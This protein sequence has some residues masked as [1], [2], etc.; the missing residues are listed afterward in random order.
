MDTEVYKDELKAI[1]DTV[2][3]GGRRRGGE[4]RE[5]VEEREGGEKVYDIDRGVSS[6]FFCAYSNIL[7][8]AAVSKAYSLDW[9]VCPPC[10]LT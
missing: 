10:G 7:W 5:S 1:F 3:V 2:G 4:K 6:S 8:F 9:V